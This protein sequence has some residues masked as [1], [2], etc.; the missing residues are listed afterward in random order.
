MFKQS[1]KKWESCLNNFSFKLGFSDKGKKR[2][3]I[4]FK[5]FRHEKNSAM[6]YYNRL[7]K[8]A[9]TFSVPLPSM[10]FWLTFFFNYC[11]SFGW[12]IL[13]HLLFF[14]C[15]I[16]VYSLSAFTHFNLLKVAS[17]FHGTDR[18]RAF[19]FTFRLSSYPIFYVHFFIMQLPSLAKWFFKKCLLFDLLNFS[20]L[21]HT[22]KKS[23]LCSLYRLY[24]VHSSAL[25]KKK[26]FSLNHVNNNTSAP[27]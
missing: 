18:Y 19:T 9:G 16:F 5:D 25:C 2:K 12:F 23:I 24:T 20:I 1:R 3:I 22:L 21:S 26:H 17:S 10:Y 8:P 7:N 11:Y 13:H 27:F 14:F 15:C 4:H 6:P